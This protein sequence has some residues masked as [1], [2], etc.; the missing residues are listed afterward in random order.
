MGNCENNCTQNSSKNAE[1]FKENIPSH[2]QKLKEEKENQDLSRI[3]SHK[4]KSRN[5]SA[6]KLDDSQL[7]SEQNII[8]FENGCTYEGEWNSQNKRHGFGVYT[9]T[10]GSKYSG[11]WENNTAHGFGRLEH[12]NGEVY[13]GNWENDKVSG[14]GEYLS[15]EGKIYKGEWIN[16]TQEGRGMEIVKGFS[17]YDGQ[18]VKGK[19]CGK[20]IIKFEDG[21]IYE[22]F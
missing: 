7:F 19:K 13:E 8:K 10:D 21:S 3:S 1:I 20:G 22:V 14:Y 12:A 11:Y 18:Y 16:D 9:W 4:V 6:K 17:T 15:I 2:F 5:S